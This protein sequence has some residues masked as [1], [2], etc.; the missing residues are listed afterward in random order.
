MATTDVPEP[1]PASKSLKTPILI[2]L[3][4]SLAGASGGFY[5]VTSGLLEGAESAPAHAV[6]GSA[7]S[8]APL[9]D[10]V[11]LEIEPLVVSLASAR[12]SRHLRFRAQLEVYAPHRAEVERMMPRVVDVL[13]TY[14][15]AL[16]IGDLEDGA[17]LIR[18]RAQMLRRIRIV[19]GGDRVADLLIMEFVLN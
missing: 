1:A 6:E 7:R 16:D 15:R 18:L 9:P 19:T 4:L 5:A 13:N 17:A 2:G 14:L 3:A 11:F 10:V 12:D 8:T